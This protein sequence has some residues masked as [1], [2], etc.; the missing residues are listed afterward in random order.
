MCGRTRWIKCFS[1]RLSRSAP[2]WERWFEEEKPVAEEFAPEA[3]V[4]LEESSQ[5]NTS[6]GTFFSK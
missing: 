6:R 4:K 2:G 1:P 5:R 3:E